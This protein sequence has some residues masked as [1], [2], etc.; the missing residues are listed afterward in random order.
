MALIEIDNDPNVGSARI[1]NVVARDHKE[2]LAHILEYEKGFSYYLVSRD[3]V[4]VQTYCEATNATLRYMIAQHA[5][6]ASAISLDAPSRQI[7][8]IDALSTPGFDMMR[9][10]QNCG[11]KP[12][13]ITSIHCENKAFKTVYDKGAVL[14]SSHY[15]ISV[16]IAKFINTVLGPGHN[17]L[18][19]VEAH[20]DTR[21]APLPHFL[22]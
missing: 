8:G 22:S 20:L 7:Q 10:T 5:I 4:C 19:E 2:K 15:A 21:M 6:G 14:I 3:D 12:D 13:E 17:V 18:P 1:F 9:I 16:A 11:V